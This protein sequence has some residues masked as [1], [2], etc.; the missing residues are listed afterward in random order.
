M[1]GKTLPPAGKPP[2]RISFEIP[3]NT[4]FNDK[5]LLV[6]EESICKIMKGAVGVTARNVSENMLFEEFRQQVKQF[7][8]NSDS[9]ED[10]RRMAIEA[11]TLVILLNNLR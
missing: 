1:F 7:S 5:D 3:N 4:F 11:M 9:P 8:K 2:I 10:A 6:F